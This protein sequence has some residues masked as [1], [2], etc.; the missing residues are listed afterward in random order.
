MIHSLYF[1]V[2]RSDLGMRSLFPDARLASRFEFVYEGIVATGSVVFKKIGGNR[3]GEMATQRFI[4][5]DRIQVSDILDSVSAKTPLKCKNKR[6]L[7]LQDTTEVNFAGRDKARTGLGEAGGD[8]SV[9]FFIHPQVAVDADSGA[10]LGLID[11][12][13]WTRE[14]QK[15]NKKEKKTKKKAKPKVRIQDVPYTDKES[16]YWAKGMESAHNRL[17]EARQVITVGDR[18]SDLYTFFAMRPR[19]SD[20]VIRV[21]FNRTLPSG[22]KLFDKAKEMPEM[23]QYC[24]DLTAKPGRKARKVTMTLRGGK[25]TLNKSKDVKEAEVPESVTLNFVEAI[26]LNP[27]EKT[28]PVVWRIY[29]TLPIETLEDMK[30]IVRFYALRWR[31]EEI[32]RALK[33][34]GLALEQTQVQSASRLFRLSALAIAAAVRIVQ[35]VDARDGS[36]RPASDAIDPALYDGVEKIGKTLEGK[37]DRQKNPHKVGN[38]AW[39]SWVV[40]RLGGW[41]CYYKPPGPKTMATGWEKLATMLSGFIIAQEAKDV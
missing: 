11:A 34:N 30:E 10:V 22:D 14:K 19:G 13:I 12:S 39:L 35:L 29:T 21:K 36:Q 9:G 3:A 23:G 40:A 20:F 31:I 15:K 7:A 1:I 16:I 4:D 28:T 37:T 26:E 17:H 27:P 6:I 41:N 5:N 18:A 8:K 24:F 25:V 2:M 32:F 33:G 38:L